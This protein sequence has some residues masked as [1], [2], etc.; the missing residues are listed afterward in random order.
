MRLNAVT[1]IAAVF[2][3]V[4]SSCYGDVAL[5]TSHPIAVPAADAGPAG[6]EAVDP[7]SPPGSVP[8]AVSSEGSSREGATP[9]EV[10]PPTVAVPASAVDA[11]SRNTEPDAGP[12]PALPRAV[13][14][15]PAA[16]L[17]LVGVA[18][19]EPRLGVCQ[20]GV[21]IGVRT[22]AN[23]SQETFGQR[24]TFLEPICGKVLESP[25]PFGAAG[26][27]SVTPDP[28]LL[29]W[30]ETDGFQGVPATEVPDPRLTWVPQPATVCPAATPVVVGLSGE[31]DPVAPDV[32]NTSAIRS[33]LVECAPLLLAQNGVDVVADESGHQFISNADAFSVGGDAAYRSSCE[34][35]SVTTQLHL[36]AGF[37]LDGF[38]LGCS[39]LHLE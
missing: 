18:E 9:L 1:A 2:C 32:T 20:G 37:W 3:C 12:A 31:Y 30:A 26:T 13:V 23:P 34:G 19:G 28:A 33:L 39:N 24:L 29:A 27:L 16:E 7:P 8:A 5:F 35:G 14:A 6:P 4:T 36:H 15:S 38:V 17:E 10:P 21:V 25:D 22:T 11:G